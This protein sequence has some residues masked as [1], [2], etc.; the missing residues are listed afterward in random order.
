MNLLLIIIISSLA[1]RTFV[2]PVNWKVVGCN[3]V[4]VHGLV[5]SPEGQRREAA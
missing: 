4:F 1:L 2:R 5:L 3:C